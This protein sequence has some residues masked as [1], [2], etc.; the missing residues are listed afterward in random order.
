VTRC[1]GVEGVRTSSTDEAGTICS[2]ANAGV[3]LRKVSGGPGN[4]RIDALGRLRAKGGAG[5]DVILGTVRG[6]I[7]G[8]GP[9]KDT[10]RGRAGDDA[11]V[12]GRGRDVG[13]GGAGTDSC[14]RVEM[15][16]GCEK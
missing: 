14:I 9:G 3:G 7:L 1:S 4:D 13:R 6:D 8:G 10:L 15:S 2:P 5:A 11:I 12:G 16:Y